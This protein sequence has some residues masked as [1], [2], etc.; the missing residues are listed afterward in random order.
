MQG[1]KLFGIYCLARRK[2]H[3]TGSEAPESYIM[4]NTSSCGQFF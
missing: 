4:H 1:A 3:L 2:Q